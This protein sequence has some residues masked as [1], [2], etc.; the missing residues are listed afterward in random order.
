MSTTATPLPGPDEFDPFAATVAELER[1]VAAAAPTVP[2]SAVPV[3][4]VR[5]VNQREHA[6]DDEGQD[7]A[8]ASAAGDT[9]RVRGLRAEV[10]EAHALLALQDDTAPLLVDTKRVRKA[11]KRSH[12]AARLHTLGQNPMARAWQ[13]ARV[14][15]VLTVTALVALVGALAWST[16]GVHHTLTLGMT[17][18]GAAWWGAWAV[19]PVISAILLVVV[20]AKAFLTTRGTT[21]H[22]P[23][24]T[25]VEFG[26]L[27]VTLTLNVWPY[28]P[29]VADTFK[30]MTLLAH[31]IGPLVAVGA[32]TVLPIIWDGF[33]HLDHTAGTRPDRTAPARPASAHP[34]GHRTDTPTHATPAGPSSPAPVSAD[35]APERATDTPIVQ[36]ELSARAAALLPRLRAAIAAGD[37]PATASASAIRAHLRCGSEYARELR[38]ALTEPARQTRPEAR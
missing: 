2:T 32:V 1:Y 35:T 5:P 24:L 30:P 19:E 18:R 7:H 3:D 34:A 8:A 25:K 27:G 15:L 20:G 11:L 29:I 36:A 14:R 16:T 37:L 23:H 13:A 26:A 4:H 22:H 6:A 9:R 21:L 10:A 28:L 12:E 38:N 17:E 33:A 31:A